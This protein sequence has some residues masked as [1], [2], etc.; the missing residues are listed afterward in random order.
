MFSGQPSC[1]QQIEVNKYYTLSAM[2]K[3]S[4]GINLVL[5][6]KVSFDSHISSHPENKLDGKWGKSHFYSNSLEVSKYSLP[7]FFFFL[8]VIV[9]SSFPTS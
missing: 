6:P 5:T 7:D 1:K 8:E 3:T 4:V 9:F 2:Q